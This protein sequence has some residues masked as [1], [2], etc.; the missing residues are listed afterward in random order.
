MTRRRKKP[1]VPF[2]AIDIQEIEKHA[3]IGLTMQEI[4]DCLGISVENL[5]R[6]KR[7]RAEIADAIR[8]GRSQGTKVLLN[9]VFQK[10]SKGDVIAAKFWLGVHANRSEKTVTELQGKD[11][12]P[13]TVELENAKAKLFRK[14]V[15]EADE[16]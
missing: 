9:T 6:K 7:E 5:Y 8:R 4:A 10:A 15:P 2:D 1:H 16:G 13:I 12:G 3:A 14:L 11:G